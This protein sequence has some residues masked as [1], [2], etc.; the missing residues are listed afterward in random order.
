MS[1]LYERDYYGWTQEQA[2][3]LKNG[4]FKSLDLGHLVEEIESL[5]RS[6]KRELKN[7]LEILMMHLLKWQFQEDFR[8]RSWAL[9]IEEQRSKILEHLDENPSLKSYFDEAF[10]KSYSHARRMA[11]LETRLNLEKF[12]AACPY[13]K[14]QILDVL[15][16]P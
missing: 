8:S 13:S 1:A 5:G 2:R 6:E 3:L 14:D 10:L 15:F 7:R 4:D 16:Y 9:T 12:P 11:A